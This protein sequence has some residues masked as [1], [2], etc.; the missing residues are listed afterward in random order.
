MTDQMGDLRG[1]EIKVLDQGFI[2]L[3]DYMGS[4]DAIV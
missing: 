2:R 4:D 3:I 1:K